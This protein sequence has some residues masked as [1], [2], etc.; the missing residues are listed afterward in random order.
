M[1]EKNRVSLADCDIAIDRDIFLRNLLRELTGTLEEVVGLDEAAGFVSIVGRHIGE[2][3]DVQYR[4]ALNAGELSLPQVGEVLVDLKRR[5]QGG[6]AITSIDKEKIVLVN[7][8]CPF[9]EKVLQR[10]SLCMMTSNVFGTV[11]AENLG[12]AKVCLRE[13]I[14]QG[15]QQ[16]QVIIYLQLNETSNQDEG[17][18][19]FKS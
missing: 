7:T 10:P 8:R 18:E 12:Y 15:D 11:T 9:G 3:M 14:A 17:R 1:M 16:C 6:F 13:T 4:K 19:Y 2:W 5:I